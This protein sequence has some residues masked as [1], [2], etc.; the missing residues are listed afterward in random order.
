MLEEN[1][2]KVKFDCLWVVGLSNYYNL[3]VYAK[4]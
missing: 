3:N 2:P 1:I 4:P